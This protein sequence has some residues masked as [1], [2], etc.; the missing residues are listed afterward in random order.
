METVPTYIVVGKS[1]SGKSFLAEKLCSSFRPS[2]VVLI[3]NKKKTDFGS[4]FLRGVPVS[5]SPWSEVPL[6]E[7]NV[8]YVLED[9]VALKGEAKEKT[10]HLLNVTSRFASS[11]VILVTHSL[12]GTGV[13]GALSYANNVILTRDRVN[14]KALRL[15]LR[16]FYYE[17]RDRIEAMFDRLR[18]GQYLH[19]TPSE[20]EASVLDTT[21]EDEREE[22]VSPTREELLALFPPPAAAIAEFVLGVMPAGSVRKPDMSVHCLDVRGRPVRVS[23]ID[24]ISC[25]ADPD[26]APDSDVRNFHKLLC[27]RIC[28]PVTLIA[29]HTLASLTH[30]EK[31]RQRRLEQAVELPK[32]VKS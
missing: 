1:G 4:R 20:M 24:Y 6:S 10:Y 25:L 30:A 9:V 32:D 8:C 14:K 16:H 7:S 27:R 31:K 5:D 28:F 19:L 15:L 2:K 17:E 3:N 29:N 23:F 12:L 13:F 26:A 22:D 11:P 18:K 21:P